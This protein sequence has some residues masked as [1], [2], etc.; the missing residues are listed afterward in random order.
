LIVL[1]ILDHVHKSQILCPCTS[2]K[3]YNFLEIG[4]LA[5]SWRTS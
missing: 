2:L 1:I 5:E 3:F 4:S